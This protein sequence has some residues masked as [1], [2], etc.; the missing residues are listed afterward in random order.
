MQNFSNGIVLLQFVGRLS[1]KIQ[2]T[3]FEGGHFS[4]PLLG[5]SFAQLFGGECRQTAHV[6]LG[7]TSMWM[8][9][10]LVVADFG[11]GVPRWITND[12]R[13][14]IIATVAIAVAR[15]G[16]GC[17][18]QQLVVDVDVVVAVVVP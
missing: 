5:S 17:Q 9:W 7:T 3:E 8:M 16:G 2:S 12:G 15:T 18:L 14:S 1:D 11:R 6:T 13:R 10:L 4:T